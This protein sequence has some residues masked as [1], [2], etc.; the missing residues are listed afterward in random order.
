MGRAIPSASSASSSEAKAASALNHPGIVTIYDITHADG[1]GLHRDGVRAGPDAGRADRAQRAEPHRRVDVRHPGGAGAGQSARD[2]HRASRSEAVQHHG[3]GRWPGEDSGLRCGEARL[4]PRSRGGLGRPTRA[5]C[6][7]HDHLQTA[8]GTTVGTIAYMSPEQAEGRPVDARSDIFSFGAVLDQMVTG[9]RAFHGSSLA[10]T[11]TAVIHTEPAPPGQLAKNLPRDLERIIQRCLRKDPTRRFHVMTDVAVELDEIK[12]EVGTRPIRVAV[13]AALPRQ[14]RLLAGFAAAAALVAS[15][16]VWWFVSRSSSADEPAATTTPLTSLAGDER[17]PTFSPD[18]GQ[19]AF[20]WDGERGDNTDI[21]VMPVGAGTPLRL[22]AN[23]ALDTAPA[24]SPYGSRVAFLRRC[25]PRAALYVLTPPLP[26]SEQKIADVDPTPLGTSEPIATTSWSADS[27]HIILAERDLKSRE[28]GIV[29]VPT[30]RSAR[31][32]LIWTAS[33]S[34]TYH[35]P[36]VSPTSNSLAYV[37]LRRGVVVRGVCGRSRC[38]DERARLAAPP[39]RTERSIENARLDGRR[40]ICHQ[41]F[42]LGR[43]IFPVAFSSVGRQGGAAR[44]RR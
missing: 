6:R 26:N 40:S 12:I 41:Q 24:W 33:A 23:P 29:V 16:A 30:D 11:L 7:S 21:Y 15:T 14:G 9:A 17:F 25:R 35:F 31:R 3:D 2:R 5:R 38:T 43:E 4:L 19:V 37:V 44:A 20:T 42:R 22:T 1:I 27:R 28:N 18:G 36:A 32:R 34:G 13:P 10:E 8:A 39:E